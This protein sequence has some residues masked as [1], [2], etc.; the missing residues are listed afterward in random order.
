M[1]RRRNS[2]PA[3]ASEWDEA[4][5]PAIKAWYKE[6]LSAHGTSA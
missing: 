4:E 6:R 3:A 2:T 5:W 1:A